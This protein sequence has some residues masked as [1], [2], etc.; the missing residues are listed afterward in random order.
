[1]AV[2]ARRT[3]PPAAAAAAASSP[4][5]PAAATRGTH[6]PTRATAKQQ[7]QPTPQIDGAANTRAKRP[8]PPEEEDD[9]VVLPAAVAP[10]SGAKRSVPGAAARAAPASSSTAAS[11]SSRTSAANNDNGAGAATKPKIV[12][13]L[14]SPDDWRLKLP[15]ARDQLANLLRSGPYADLDPGPTL[16]IKVAQLL[17]LLGHPDMPWTTALL[18]ELY[19]QSLGGAVRRRRTSSSSA[20][21]GSK[22]QGR[23]LSAVYTSSASMA[24]EWS[25]DD[26]ADI[27]AL[28]NDSAEIIQPWAAHDVPLLIDLLRAIHTKLDEQM[29]CEAQK[30]L[31]PP[32]AEQSVKKKPAAA[33]ALSAAAA[34][35]VP[36]PRTNES[37]QLIHPLPAVQLQQVRSIMELIRSH[38]SSSP[39]WGSSDGSLPPTAATSIA[40]HGSFFRCCLE[41]LLVLLPTVLGQ[42]DTK[43]G[44]HVR[45][46]LRQIVVHEV[47]LAAQKHQARV[48]ARAKRSSS[49]PVQQQSADDDLV[50]S[51]TPCCS[52]CSLSQPLSTRPAVAASSSSSSTQA[53]KLVRLTPLRSYAPSLS[54]P[55]DA[56]L[57]MLT[58]LH[59][60]AGVWDDESALSFQQF[61]STQLTDSTMRLTFVAHVRPPLLR[62]HVAALCMVQLL[63]LVLNSS[64]LKF[65]HGLPQLSVLFAAGA[66]NFTG[67]GGPLSHDVLVAHLSFASSLLPIVATTY[68]K[69]AQK[70]HDQLVALRSKVRDATTAFQRQRERPLNERM[71]GLQ[72]KKEEEAA[73][74]EEYAKSHPEILHTPIFA[75]KMAGSSS[76]AAAAEA[77][78]VPASSATGGSKPSS[79]GA[80]KQLS[81]KEALASQ[82]LAAR[83]EQKRRELTPQQLEA[84]QAAAH[85]AA[86]AERER[87]EEAA[88][89]AERDKSAAKTAVFTKMQSQLSELLALFVGAV[90]EQVHHH[91]CA[92]HSA[93]SPSAPAAAASA[94]GGD[95]VVIPD[96]QPDGDGGDGD[97]I[98]EDD[99][100][101]ASVQPLVSGGKSSSTASTRSG[102]GGGKGKNRSPS[103]KKPALPPQPCGCR[104]ATSVCPQ[105]GPQ[106]RQI[107]EQLHALQSC[108]VVVH[109]PSAS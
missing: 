79:T 17:D 56:A 88:R 77:A 108:I 70:E 10:S 34:T 47:R 92:H 39:F 106:Y 13:L 60:M 45:D 14:L 36:P 24:D 51:N 62:M 35:V 5:Q 6:T 59:C 66:D 99:G 19:E 38:F 57:A 49:L 43:E 15:P 89:Q 73:K 95:D 90:S 28:L 33:G 2:S 48:E 40:A 20:S 41:S 86:E 30:Q 75:E 58:H 46:W 69:E 55:G 22:E 98:A 74:W 25:L 107:H 63:Q 103:K 9:V 65:T 68:A 72:Q 97:T 44:E 67:A 1:V 64:Y 50:R 81:M 12:S 3:A 32:P 8:P 102:K 31:Q 42:L 71:L 4:N 7:Q 91:R 84:Q 21:S 101:D 61:L 18:L 85:R 27:A 11:G 52:F 80:K 76:S 54:S 37:I 29:R 96:S 104:L 109:A 78:V 87:K 16:G 105:L 53:M 23:R 26:G 93:T 100:A 94:V 83:A 82:A